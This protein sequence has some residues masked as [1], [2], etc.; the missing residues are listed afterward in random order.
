MLHRINRLFEVVCTCGIGQQG[1]GDSAI[2][3]GR[4]EKGNLV[5]RKTR[6]GRKAT[7]AGEDSLQ[8]R[9][10][11]RGVGRATRGGQSGRMEASLGR[12]VLTRFRGYSV[13]QSCHNELRNIRRR[14]KI[15]DCIEYPKNNKSLIPQR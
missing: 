7:R 9:H 8:A 15:F 6:F 14:R 13:L 12:A 2:R 4:D 10:A 5:A 1:L 11:S 3:I